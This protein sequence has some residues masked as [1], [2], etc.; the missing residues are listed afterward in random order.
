MC[1]QCAKPAEAIYD[2]LVTLARMDA[3]RGQWAHRVE[4]QHVQIV[5][6]F[7]TLYQLA[8]LPHQWERR[9]IYVSP[10]N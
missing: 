7:G 9:R 1:E 6:A 4:R 2:I 5:T 8:G 3:E 10:A